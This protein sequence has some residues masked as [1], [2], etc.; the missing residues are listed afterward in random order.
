MLKEIKVGLCGLGTVGT[1]VVKI[2]KNHQ[3]EIKYKLGCEIV[4]NKILVHDIHK[5]RDIVVNPEWLTS[6]PDELVNN[7][8]IDVIVEVM[9]GIDQTNLLIEQALRNNKHIVTANKDMM[10][11]HGQK[12]LKL[13]KAN[14]CDIF[15]DASV[16][17]GIPILR[18]LSDGLASDR[19]QKIMGIVNGTTN[20][21]LTKMT[22]DHL[23][24]DP[25]LKE[26]QELGFAESDPT[27]DVDGL[28]AARKMTLLANL[29]F[30]MEI[31]LDDVEV[32]G[33]SNI[34][35]EDISFADSLGYTI[36]LIGIA[37]INNGKVEVSVEPTLL[38]KDHPLALVKNEYNAVY[39]YGE[40][41][42]ETM[43]Y[44]PG[45]GSMPTATAVVSDLMEVIKN[46]RLGISG[47]SYVS[48]QYETQL[49]KNEEKYT[50]YFIRMEVDDE[51]GTFQKITNV[52]SD[53]KV[54]FAKILQLP[55]SKKETAEIVMVTHQISKQ[56]LL[57]SLDHLQGLSVVNR[58]ISYYRVDGEE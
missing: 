6:N 29:A 5:P 50:K 41:V 15:Y 16:A 22:D 35:Q 49:K 33:I 24:F 36:K 28:D 43:F 54:S 30:K 47:N 4:V 7:P 14:N 34:S 45:A 26:A 12:L 44:G 2:L 20:Y 9:G 19:I 1:G 27:S 25:V 13:A 51:A 46:I 3:E 42:G 11:V 53:E 31:G 21:I 38:P 32:S 17:G 37:S 18:S 48:P 57:N 40:A 23:A 52:F 58:I 10:A 8:E 39:V 55:G 56:Q